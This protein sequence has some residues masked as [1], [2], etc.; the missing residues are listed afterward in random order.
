LSWLE[1]TPDKGEV[2]G[3]N[4]AKPTRR[5]IGR[6]LHLDNC[7]GREGNARRVLTCV[8]GLRGQADEGAR[9]MPRRQGPKKDGASAETPRGAASRLRSGDVRMGQPARGNALASPPEST[10]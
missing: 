1:R 8:E 3:S 10:R 7:T 5:P 4:P 6:L 9:W 2:G